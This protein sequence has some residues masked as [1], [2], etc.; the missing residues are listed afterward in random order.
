M[1]T[2]W[3]VVVIPR[4]VL[5]TVRVAFVPCSLSWGAW[6]ATSG[7]SGPAAAGKTRTTPKKAGGTIAVMVVVV[8]TVVVVTVMVAATAVVE[9]FLGPTRFEVRC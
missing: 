2:P 1:V 5:A 9:G 3:A 4:V 6:A 8:V 7:E